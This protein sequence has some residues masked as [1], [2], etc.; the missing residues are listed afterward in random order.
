MP[1]YAHIRQ[2]ENGETIYQTVAEHL[3]GTAA[4][5]REFA[6]DFGAEADGDL[7]GLAHD[8]GKCT[9]AFQKR[10]LEG[11]PVVDHTTAGMLTCIR[12]KRPSAAAC[13]A[14]HHGGLLDVGNLRTDRAGEATL[15]GRFKKGVEGHYLERC[16]ESGV[17][18]PTL[19]P[20][21]PE[22]DPL[23]ASFRT[24]MLYSCLVDADFLDTERFMDGER[25]R[26]GYDDLPTLLRRLKEYIAP[27]QNPK[28]ALNKLRC[29]ILNS[30]LDTG[31]KLKGIYTLT[32]P[33]GG[34]KTVASLAFALRH[35]VAH[36]MR[37][38]IYVVL[39]TSIIEQNAEVFRE[40]L[41]DGNVLE[42][43]SG[44]QF[45][46]SDGASPEEVRRALAAENWDMPV[47]VTTAVQFF[48]SIYANRSSKCRKLHNLADS[49]IIFDEAQMLPLCH[50]RP[51]V[52]AMA[53]LAEQFR[54]TLVLCT[55]TQPSL[56]DL[57]HTYAP[58]CPITE[59]CPQTAEE[60]DSF[61][62]VTFR[63]EGILEDDVL[64]EKLSEHR[65]VLCIVNSRKAAQSI[66]ARLP[67][68]ASFHLS[69]LMVPAQRQ[70]L[71][72]EIR[73]R[74]KAGEP[75]R[76][77]STSLIE[78]G[79]DV[80]FPAVYREL[81]GLDSVLQAAGRCNRE[82][83]RAPEESIVTVFERAELP[84]M[85][86]RTAIG[87]TREALMN[88][89]DIG[90]RETMQNY[91]D[92][93]RSL[94][95]ETL[96]KSGVIKAFEKGINGCE[97]PF[98]TVAENFHLIDQ[99]TRT[100]YV[101]FGGGAALIE[102]L[103][104]GECSKGLYRKL[105]RYAV[106]VYEPHFQK[107]YAAGALLD[108]L[109]WHPGLRWVIDRIH[110]CAPI[111][112]TNIRRNEVKDV[113]SARRAKTVMEKGQGELYLAASE[114]IQQRAA[115]VLRDVHYV[116]DAHFDM[117]DAAAPG[118]NPGKFQ[119]MIKRRLEKGQ[120][121]SMPYFGTREFPAQFRR[122]TELPP[123][124]DELKGTRDLGWMLWDLDYSDP[125][126]ITP[127]FFRA[128]LVDGVM[129]VPPPNSGEVRG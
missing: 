104:A 77:V 47:I 34:G 1:Y 102:R 127:K 70:T 3:T 74:L 2:D 105:G 20:E 73:R 23:K 36:G 119:D 12:M 5:C 35:A 42:H 111:R 13:V 28:T 69:T 100:V 96:D 19:P 115:M 25:G 64:A 57:L 81:A 75:C 65:Q 22:R 26:G 10:L 39:Y 48:E 60:Y 125:A 27:W 122:C 21:T 112:F 53:S 99:N 128:S 66:F 126:N 14:G 110:V 61:R 86:F 38:V 118:D 45:E 85:L 113:I 95:G 120:C 16:G 46:L 124:P 93:L 101:P 17:T 80:D 8:L 7:M 72:D 82:G 59:L 37:R 103:K 98:R 54:S 71:L 116:I 67:Q 94:S 79:V 49:V 87:A 18:L 9:D 108:S 33:T 88:S 78:A 76:V 44:V 56:G 30:C 32:V 58:S 31:S 24:R 6:A 106:S 129:T 11:G 92:A 29:K 4:L 109:Y 89:C 91:F 90:A 107:L 52:A 83:K 97:L 55:A 68:E 50:L 62:R 15:S 51:C 123:C 84:P 40:I 41:G 117:T 43:H 63:Q 121:Y 114:S